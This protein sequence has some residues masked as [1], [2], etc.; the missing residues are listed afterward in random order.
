LDRCGFF[1]FDHRTPPLEIAMGGQGTKPNKK[2]ETA[3][4]REMLA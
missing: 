2:K 3:M 1:C 4:Q